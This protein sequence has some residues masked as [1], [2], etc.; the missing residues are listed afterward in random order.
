M[1]E[2]AVRFFFEILTQPVQSL[3]IGSVEVC[4]DQSKTRRYSGHRGRRCKQVLDL[5]LV[6]ALRILGRAHDKGP[7]VAATTL[8]FIVS[9]FSV[10]HRTA[11]V[12]SLLN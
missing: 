3:S 6:S 7:F 1:A 9:P 10:Q 8:I 5:R 11:F 2:T 4:I 12:S